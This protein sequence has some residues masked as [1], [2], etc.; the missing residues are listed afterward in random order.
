MITSLD[1]KQL[2]KFTSRQLNNY[3]PDNR[4]VKS[5]ELIDQIAISL[6]KVN[7][8]FSKVVSKYYSI[9]YEPYFNHLNGDHYATFLYFLSREYYLSTD[10]IDICDKIFYLNK[11][12]HGCDIFYQVEL[13]DIFILV[14]PTGTVLGRADY[15]DYLV[16]YQGV[17]VGSNNDLFPKIGKYV[18]L[19][20]G[21]GVFG[22]CKVNSNVE[23]GVD[24]F[25][26]DCTIPS[27]VTVVGQY[28][29]HRIINKFT[30]FSLWR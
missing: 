6:D 8:C 19:R 1:R 29:N 27:N 7:F 3:F 12:L 4:L 24:A 30:Q 18:T 28:P 9:G 20:P 16:I 5:E 13:P 2:S 11:A 21:C 25:I 10:R 22:E 14:H 26:K 15:S 17:R 23:F